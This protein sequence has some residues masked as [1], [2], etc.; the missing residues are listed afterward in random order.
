MDKC[1]KGIRLVLGPVVAALLVT[2]CSTPEKV[3]YLRDIDPN[4]SIVLQEARQLTLKPGD[5]L[6]IHVFSRDREL[7][8]LF[9]IFEEGNSGGSLPYTIDEEGNI[10]MP[11]L[12]RIHVQGLTRLQ[13][14]DQ[15]KYK[16]LSAQ[17]LNDPTVLVEYADMAFYV[18]GEVGRPG[19]IAIP[20]DK[21]TLLEGLSLAGDLTI[22]GRR[23]NVLVMRSEKG[24]QNT[25]KVDLTDVRSVYS[26]PAFYLQQDDMIYVEPNIQKANQSDQNANL[27]RTPGF[28]FSTV[29]FISSVSLLLVRFNVIKTD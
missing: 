7:A 1:F 21:V 11:I 15:V 16:L 17:L 28:W 27:I 8:S 18:L 22:T 10:E 19:R 20:K 6:Q 2:G 26:S 12:G 29:S 14:A 23:D 4:S 5:R 9:N 3:G 13:L 24:V 25:Y